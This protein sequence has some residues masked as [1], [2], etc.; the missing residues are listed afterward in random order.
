MPAKNL[1]RIN[2][3]GVYLHIYNKGADKRIIFN[4]EKDYEVF[5]GFLKGYLTVPQDPESI[6]KSFTVHGRIFRGTPHQPKN[7][8]NKVEL[9]AYSLMPDHFHLLLHQKTRG[10][11]ESFMRSLCTRYSMY[12]NKKYQHTGALFEGPYKSVLIK[13]ESRLLHPTRFLHH[14]G[15]YSSYAEYL[16]TRVTSWVKPKVVL[17]F[18]GK[19]TGSYKDFVEKYELSQKE[20]ELIEGIILESETAHLERRGL[21]RN[22]ENPPP[23]IFSESSEKIHTES[24][25]K[26]H[27]RIP[28]FLATSVVFL[29]LLTFGIR[30][31]MAST[32]KS[33]LTSSTVPSTSSEIKPT[34]SA[35]SIPDSPTF[36]SDHLSLTD[37]L[38]ISTSSAVLSETEN[39]QEIKPKIILTVK[40]DGSSASS[41]AQ[42]NIR[43][44][45]TTASRKIGQARDGDT[46]EFVSI[47]SGW[48]EVKLATGSGFISAAFIK[49]G[50]ANNQ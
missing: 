4:D 7:Y 11:L 8:F 22:V 36:S 44:K 43:Q 1:S 29:L 49:K 16:G 32:A 15:G 40:I 19:G 41:S 33:S 34:I 18:F 14:N 50:E 30:N 9:I 45:P 48:Y 17:S 13:D 38:N 26:P 37:M 10:S 21:A 47:D 5:L 25:L 39:I 27:Q 12:F 20:K 23:E 46:F 42:V 24:N 6:K 28:E 31:I 35:T 3:G 2:V